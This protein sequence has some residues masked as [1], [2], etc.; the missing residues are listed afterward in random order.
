[1]IQKVNRDSHRTVS[2]WTVSEKKEVP[3]A[4]GQQPCSWRRKE[5]QA[6]A[7]YFLFTRKE[8]TSILLGRGQIITN[9]LRT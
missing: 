7:I 4:G 3:P 1:M 2:F 6:D 9:G 5:P 8:P